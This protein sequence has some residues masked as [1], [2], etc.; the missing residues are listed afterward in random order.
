MGVVRPAR[1]EVCECAECEILVRAGV[2][3]WSLEVL[4]RD[5]GECMDVRYVLVDSGVRCE[6]VTDSNGG[7]T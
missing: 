7:V 3:A 5:S 2:G 4:T 6:V 1:S